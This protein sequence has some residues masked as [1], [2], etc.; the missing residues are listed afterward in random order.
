MGISQRSTKALT[1]S[2]GVDWDSA[3]EQWFAVVEEMLERKMT[4]AAELHN[5]TWIMAEKL[6]DGGAGWCSGGRG[7]EGSDG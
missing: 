6:G 4:V 7:E 1:S 3:T 2:D 5:E